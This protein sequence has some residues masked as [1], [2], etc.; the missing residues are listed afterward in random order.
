MAGEK[1]K[2][3]TVWIFSEQTDLNGEHQ[4]METKAAGQLSEREDVLYLLYE[5][6]GEGKKTQESPVKNLLK[7]EKKPLKVSL[8]KSGEV[9]WKTFFE[10]GER[11]ISAYRT[12]YGALT[13]E[14][15]TESVSFEQTEHKISLQLA[16]TLFIQGEKQAACRLKME[17]KQEI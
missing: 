2:K 8:K 15:E 16:Y 7:I 10:T 11:S 4:Y 1:K 6:E 14:V 9:S 13:M 3:V 12:P 17:I 5:E